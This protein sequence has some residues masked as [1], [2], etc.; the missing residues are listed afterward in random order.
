ML[1][2]T[3]LDSNGFR[4][5]IILLWY[6]LKHICEWGPLTGASNVHVSHFCTSNKIAIDETIL[7]LQNIK[8]GEQALR[9][10]WIIGLHTN[11][12]IHRIFWVVHE[13]IIIRLYFITHMSEPKPRF[14]TQCELANQ[15][16]AATSVCRNG[17][18]Y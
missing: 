13:L 6:P 16:F 15:N 14:S 8:I 2:W 10:L 11:F 9:K 3:Q 1:H 4:R 5:V 18:L 12:I 7:S 17:G